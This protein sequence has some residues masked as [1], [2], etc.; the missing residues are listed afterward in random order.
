MS[1]RTSIHQQD[2]PYSYQGTVSNLEKCVTANIGVLGGDEVVFF[3]SRF[4][5]DEF[6]TVLREM[7]DELDKLAI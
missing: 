4:Q 6:A 1:T 7:A 3:L 5:V 2:A